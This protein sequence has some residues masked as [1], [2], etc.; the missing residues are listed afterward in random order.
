M[1]KILL[2]SASTRPGSLNERVAKALEIELAKLGAEVTHVHLENYQMPIYDSH[3]EEAEGV[4]VA[5]R[6]LYDLFKQHQGIFIASPEYN[7]S[8]TP[9]LKN[10]LD[11]ISRVRV[12]GEPPMACFKDRAFAIGSASPGAMGGYRGLLALRQILELGLGA[13]VLPEMISV[14]NA[15]ASITEDGVVQ[16]E[17]LRNFLSACACA[18][19]KMAN[20]LS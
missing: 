8:V 15:S 1:T 11:W 17:R 12:E 16:D 13:M 9:L 4:P 19:V 20:K 7:A 2:F 18:L 6:T 14:N 10:T 3:I 5:A